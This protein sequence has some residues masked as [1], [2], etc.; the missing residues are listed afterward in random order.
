MIGQQAVPRR[1]AALLRARKLLLKKPLMVA[2]VGTIL[3]LSVIAVTAPVITRY[4]PKKLNPVD[5]LEG[6]SRAHWFGT[7]RLGRDLYTRTVYGGRISLQIGFSVAA[8]TMVFGALIGMVSGYF[9]RLDMVIMALMD[10]LM[11]IPTLLLAIALMALLG[12]SMTNVIISLVVAMAPRAAR[13]VRASVL[14]LREE[15][16]VTAATAIGS[17]GWRIMTYHIFPGTFAPLVVHGTFTMAIAMLVE[18]SLSFLGAGTGIEAPSWGNLMSEGRTFIQVAPWMTL[19]PGTA[20]FL[21]VL[22]ANLAG[23]G[24]RDILDPKLAGSGL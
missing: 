23:D 18:A 6:P 13:I 22:A 8:L 12:A 14:T 21:T 3:F 9:R 11:S 20:L 10:G 1:S 7:D 17:P 15:L 19:F 2:A 4:E 5:R 24:L 16:Y